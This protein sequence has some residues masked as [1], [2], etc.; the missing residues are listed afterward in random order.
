MKKLGLI[1]AVKEEA[2]VI[3]ANHIFKWKKKDSNL[4]VSEAFPVSLSICGIGKAYAV[5]GLSKILPVSDS[6][7]SMGTSGGLG[8]EKIGDIYLVDE[9]AEHDMDVTGLGF[10]LGLTPFSNMKTPIIRSA[11]ESYISKLSDYLKKCGIEYKKGRTI[12]GDSFLCDPEITRKKKEIFDAGLADMETAA[13]AKIC[14]TEADVNFAA[15]RYITDNANHDS[16][17]NWR[18]N[19]EKSSHIFNQILTE[20]VRNL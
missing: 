20:I 15:I 2:A 13:A 16:A 19:V 7:L 3:L 18:E 10:P 5:Y 1:I 17:G 9:F 12:S 8:N 4:Y 6:I 14:S 11:D